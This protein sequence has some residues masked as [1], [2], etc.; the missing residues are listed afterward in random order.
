MRAATIVGWLAW[1][2]YNAGQGVA[3]CCMTSPSPKVEGCKQ[4]DNV[5]ALVRGT[6]RW[7]RSFKEPDQDYARMKTTA[8]FDILE[9]FHS[10]SQLETN[11]VIR[12]TF[13]S[14]DG[15]TNSF[16]MNVGEEYGLALYR[17]K[18]RKAYIFHSG[19][20][21]VSTKWDALKPEEQSL[22]K[23]CGTGKILVRPSNF[24]HFHDDDFGNV[25]FEETL[26]WAKGKISANALCMISLLIL[27][28]LLLR[29]RSRLHRCRRACSLLRTEIRLMQKSNY[30]QMNEGKPLTSFK[31]SNNDC[32]S[33]C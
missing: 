31:S 17:D 20:D 33:W 2:M 4:L 19:C 1:F 29:Y 7:L 28:T 13:E 9:V 23:T 10:N 22:W 26:E 15:L 14:P 6:P 24:T 5:D 18:T 32:K 16:Y 21:P 27:I 11:T 12:V 8:V 3:G 25:V 30:N